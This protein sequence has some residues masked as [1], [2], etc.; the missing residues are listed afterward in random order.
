MTEPS[1]HL[2]LDALADALAARDDGPGETD[3]DADRHLAGCASCT[4]RLAELAAAEARV[5]AALSTLPDP[6]LPAGLAERI[7]AA[8]EAEPPLEA[9]AADPGATVTPLAPARLRRRW[10]PAAAAAVLAVSGAGL[11]YTV[12]SGSGGADSADTSTAAGAEADGRNEAQGAPVVGSS[13]I[14]WADP[15]AVDAAL[16]QVL[17]VSTGSSVSTDSGAVQAPA[18]PLTADAP[19]ATTMQEGAAPGSGGSRTAPLPP[20]VALSSADPLAALRTPEG[21]ASCVRALLSEQ[22]RASGTQPLALDYASF[23]GSPALA[24][25][26]PDPDPDTVSAFIVG[27]GC[28]EGNEDVLGYVRRPRP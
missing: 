21:L 15:A 27:P 10:L 1:P 8:L 12:L 4:S 26:L 3:A 20:G 22:E 9:P 5:V 7:T 11:G 14:D 23:K 25:V 6:P 2:D 17:G 13:G 28:R 18:A 16:P 24:V 19:A